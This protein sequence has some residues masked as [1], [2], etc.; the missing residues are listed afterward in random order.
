MSLQ[1]KICG[2]RD[3]DNI[4]EVSAL[5]P[6]YMGFIFYPGSSRFV[7]GE[8]PQLPRGIRKTGV[9]VN[10]TAQQVRETVEKYGLDAVQLHGEESPAFCRELRVCFG[11][12]SA[13]PEI[14]KV[15]SVGESFDF[16]ELQPY[17]AFVDLFLFDTLGKQKGG[18]GVPF[19][20]DILKGYPSATPF[21]L[22]GGIGPDAL[23]A[24]RELQQYFNRSHRPSVLK[25]I[26]VNSRFETAPAL[27]NSN[28]LKIFRQAL[29][30]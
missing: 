13:S 25:G 16:T 1:L 9:F 4:A 18:N 6:E 14:I 2:M 15:F 17:E 28:E 3:P 12:R 22:S 21:F 30:D 29:L 5:E 7:E 24:I 8:L 19:N 11:E 10:A 20:W 27:K 23:P 26:D